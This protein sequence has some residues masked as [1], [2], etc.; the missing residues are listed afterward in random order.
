M[1]SKGTPTRFFYGAFNNLNIYFAFCSR[2]FLAS[3]INII[4]GTIMPHRSTTY[5]DAA[6]CYRPS[7]GLSVCWFVTVVS[8]AKTPQPIEM[9]FGLWT[10]VGPRKHVLDR[11]H[12]DTTWRIPLNCPYVAAM[13]PFCQITGHLLLLLGRI[14]VLCIR[15]CGLLLPTD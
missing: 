2:I 15:R 9:P 5:V 1:V 6:C 8:P 14:I 13:R 12:T 11:V 4:T 3:T 10:R 7:S